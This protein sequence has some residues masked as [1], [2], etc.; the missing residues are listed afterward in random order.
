MV[1]GCCK[2]SCWGRGRSEQPENT[3]SGRRVQGNITNPTH[4]TLG[5]LNQSE[6]TSRTI[7]RQSKPTSQTILSQSGHP[8]QLPLRSTQR[9]AAIFFLQQEVSDLSVSLAGNGIRRWS[10][11]SVS[12][13]K[14][15]CGIC[16]CAGLGRKVTV[17]SWFI[18]SP[19]EA[20][21]R[22]PVCLRGR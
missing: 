18:C 3:V 19:R 12:V 11:L 2:W 7:L 4:Q 5:I 1:P 17:E 20:D 9:S 14:L 6:P 15:D 21:V 22:L 13:R 8:L 16:Q 10:E